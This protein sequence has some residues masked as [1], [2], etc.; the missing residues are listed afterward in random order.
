MIINSIVPYVGIVAGLLIPKLKK[1]HDNKFTGDLYVT[2][3]TGM[4]K[5]KDIQS[6]AEYVI[7]FKYSG[8]LNIVY[9]TMMYG[10]GM[11][12]LFPI[13]AFNFFNQ[14]VCERLTVAL[15]VKQP[16][17]LDAKLT[18]NCIS[19][20]KWSPLFLLFNGYWMLSNKQIFL[21]TWEF[22]EKST[23]SMKSEHFIFFGVNWASPILLISF[24]AVFLISI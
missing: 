3:K 6:G 15:L 4:Q 18:N 2:R 23:D 16:P 9:I 11:P 20:L 5:Y 1:A 7:H 14:W 22:I 17:A 21:N 13:A 24:S 8:I 19:L 12:I 10:V